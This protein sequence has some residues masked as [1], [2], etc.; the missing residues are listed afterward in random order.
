MGLTRDKAAVSAGLSQYCSNGAMESQVN[1]LKFIKRSIPT[2]RAGTRSRQFRPAEI[3]GNASAS[4]LMS[5][6]NRA[7][8]RA[9]AACTKMSEEPIETNSCEFGNGVS[10]GSQPSRRKEVSSV[11]GLDIGP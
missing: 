2:L 11:Y 1:R 9:Q 5:S 4:Y 10:I 3:A 7:Q 8:G 6:A